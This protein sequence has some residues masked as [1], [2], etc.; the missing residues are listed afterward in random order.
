VSKVRLHKDVNPGS[1]CGGQVADGALF[2]EDYWCVYCGAKWS[3]QTMDA[4]DDP[5][6]ACG[7]CDL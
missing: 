5:V 3:D 6:E 1:A 7:R 2:G 4:E